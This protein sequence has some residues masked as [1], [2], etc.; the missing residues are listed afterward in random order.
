MDSWFGELWLYW[1]EFFE[2]NQL[3]DDHADSLARR[4]VSSDIL[5]ALP[6]LPDRELLAHAIA[7]ECDAMCTW[8]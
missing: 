7:Y 5:A 4:L 2:Q 8:D 3:S 1:R 6:D